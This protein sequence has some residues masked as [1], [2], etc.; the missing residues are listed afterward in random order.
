MVAGVGPA[1][2]GQAIHAR[3]G[4]SRV[5]GSGK[6]AEGRGQIYERQ[7]STLYLI[8]EPNCPLRLVLGSSSYLDICEP[9]VRPQR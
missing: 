6:E 4:S 2:G 7:N 3:H 1:A 5:V 8:T 9:V